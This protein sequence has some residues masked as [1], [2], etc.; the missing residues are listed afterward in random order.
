MR[1][2]REKIK[3]DTG[4]ALDFGS[5]YSVRDAIRMAKAFEPYGL[6]WIEDP[7]RA[8]NVQALYEV[9]HSTS[10][11]ILSSR[12]QLRNMRQMAGQI[13]VQQAARVLA[14][15]FGSVGGLQ[16]GKKITDLADLYS[17]PMAIH[18]IASPV[19]TVAAAQASSTMD[20]FIALEHHAIEVPWWDELVTDEEVIADGVYTINE[21]PGLGLQLN[22]TVVKKHLKKGETYF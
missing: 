18:N 11:P 4:L 22:E 8:D 13:I 3:P 2:I 9:T 5:G 7:I 6:E 12:T 20:N 21:K 14:I 17:I 10:V 15:D 1:T 16:E 19:G